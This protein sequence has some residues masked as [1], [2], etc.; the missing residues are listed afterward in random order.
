M[1]GCNYYDLKKTLIP[2]QIAEIS[3]VRESFEVGK[4]GLYSGTDLNKYGKRAYEIGLGQWLK[5]KGIEGVKAAELTSG[6]EVFS[7]FVMYLVSQ[8]RLNYGVSGQLSAQE[9]KE[10]IKE[11]EKEL[12]GGLH[13]FDERVSGDFKK[14]V[15]FAQRHI[16]ISDFCRGYHEHL[17]L[18]GIEKDSPKGTSRYLEIEKDI[19]HKVRMEELWWDK[20]GFEIDLYNEQESELQENLDKENKNGALANLEY[21]YVLLVQLYNTYNSMVDIIKL[22]S[23]EMGWSQIGESLLIKME[24]FSIEGKMLSFGQKRNGILRRIE[25]PSYN[26]VQRIDSLVGGERFEEAAKL[27]KQL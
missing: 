3:K 19:S 27:Q 2:E 21:Q 15:G 25:D 8:G 20:L 1:R 10:Q 13:S 4:S 9:K 12:V 7:G 16:D 11:A 18:L 22:Q 17:N 14:G 23:D 24:D 6:P 26:L 5:Y